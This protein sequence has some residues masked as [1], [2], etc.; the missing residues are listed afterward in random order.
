MFKIESEIYKGEIRRLLE[1]WAD[2]RSRQ[3][4]LLPGLDLQQAHYI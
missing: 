2:P 3:G 4:G 1:T